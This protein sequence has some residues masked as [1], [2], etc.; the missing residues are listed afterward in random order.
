M[1]YTWSIGYN[2]SRSRADFLGDVLLIVG[3]TSH[4]IKNLKHLANEM[5]SIMIERD[6]M[7]LSQDVVSLVTNAPINETLDII[8]KRLEDN[9]E[10]KL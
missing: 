10:L 2:V 4:H 5:A 3:K 9:T 6:D 7:F 8:K 1:N